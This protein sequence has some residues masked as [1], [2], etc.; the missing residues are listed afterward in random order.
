MLG[1]PIWTKLCDLRMEANLIVST[2]LD[3]SKNQQAVEVIAND[4]DI[5]VMLFYHWQDDMASI[6]IQKVTGGAKRQ[7]VGPSIIHSIQDVSA[8]VDP[9]IKNN[10]L[11]IH[12]WSGCDTTSSTFGNNKRLS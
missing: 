3:F 6:F 2:A 5:M 4:T 8:E 10:I 7:L 1:A 11:F 12:A 9:L